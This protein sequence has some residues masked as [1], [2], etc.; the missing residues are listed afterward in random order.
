MPST[1]TIR[2]GKDTLELLIHGITDTPGFLTQVCVMSFLRLFS[3]TSHAQD[4]RITCIVIIFL[5][6]LGAFFRDHLSLVCAAACQCECGLGQMLSPHIQ[7][8]FA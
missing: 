8:E 3:L 6:H 2:K 4:T 7:Q 5:A 1:V